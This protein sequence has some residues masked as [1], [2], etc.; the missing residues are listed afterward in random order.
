MFDKI[1]SD[2]TEEME[3]D[4]HDVLQQSKTDQ[5]RT[6]QNIMH[7]RRVIWGIMEKPFFARHAQVLTVVD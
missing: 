4:D 3:E 5:S 2:E 1:Y 6:M 7:T